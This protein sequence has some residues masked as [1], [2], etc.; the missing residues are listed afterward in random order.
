M[1]E[2]TIIGAGLAGSEA[3][4]QAAGRGCKV[5][6]YEMRPLTMTPAHKTGLMAELVCSNSLKSKPTHT[7]HGLLKEE[8]RIL[9]SHLLAITEKHAVPAGETLAVDR[10]AFAAAVTQEI[11]KHNNI[12]VQ[13]TELQELPKDGITVL[14]AGPLISPALSQSLGKLIGQSHLFFFDAVA[15]VVE[16]VSLDMNKIFAASRYD[17]GAPDYL[18]CPMTKDEYMIFLNA[19]VA[20]EQHSLKDFEAGHFFEGCLPVEEIARR[21]IKSLAFGPMKPVGLVNPADGRRPY[22]VVQLRREDI[23]GQMYN[24]VGFQTRLTESEQQRVFRTIPGLENAVFYRYGKMHRNTFLCAPAVLDAYFRLKNAPTIFVAGQLSGSEGYTEAIATGLIAG[25][26]AARSANGKPPVIPP[27][28]TAIGSLFSHLA[29]ASPDNFQPMNFNFGLLPEL[30]NKIKDKKEKRLALAQRALN[31]MGIWFSAL[32]QNF[33][34][35]V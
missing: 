7:P 32:D 35:S 23:D 21:G 27:P 15:P 10:D 9:G 29:A 16:A 2:I 24:L 11:E 4:L 17:R 30:P 31:S 6:L 1:N 8:L 19:L 13:R 20:A 18:N 26:N 22:A 14:S 5:I 33:V 25:L 28:D 3:A 34:E 12:E